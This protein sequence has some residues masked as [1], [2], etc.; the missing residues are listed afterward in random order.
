M[1][2]DKPILSGA[3]HLDNSVTL[4]HRVYTVLEESIISGELAPGQHLVEARLAADL[5][6]SR[7][8]VREAIQGLRQDG[9][10]V[11]RP[12]QGSF[13]RISNEKEMVDLFQ[14]R[15]VL[16]TETA[17]IAARNSSAPIP[18]VVSGAFC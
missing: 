12:R 15:L 11:D 16:E 4:R 13:V 18:T 7:N 1:G 10:I 8:P 2:T 17:R 9:W 14:V 6:V 3:K 5:G